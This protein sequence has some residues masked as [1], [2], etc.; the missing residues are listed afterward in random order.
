MTTRYDSTFLR[1]IAHGEHRSV[2][3]YV[4]NCDCTSS[5]RAQSSWRADDRTR[6][7]EKSVTIVPHRATNSANRAASRLQTFSSPAR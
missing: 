1:Q 6:T 7:V 3:Q 5:A 4:W 2:E